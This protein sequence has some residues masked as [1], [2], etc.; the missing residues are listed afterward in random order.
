MRGINKN[1]S[2]KHLVL[3][4]LTEENEMK[5]F[6]HEPLEILEKKYLFEILQYGC[7]LL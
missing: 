7:N 2:K 4:K 5:S 1:N 3:R 6:N